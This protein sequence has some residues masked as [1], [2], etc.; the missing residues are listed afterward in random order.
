MNRLF[1]YL[2]ENSAAIITALIGVFGVLL[3]A[4]MTY[5]ATLRAQKKQTIDENLSNALSNFFKAYS[6]FCRTKSHEEFS[7]L[8]ASLD[9][10]RLF[11]PDDALPRIDELAFSLCASED[12]SDTTA[13]IYRQLVDLSRKKI[14]HY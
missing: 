11:C 2:L 13:A 8:L 12:I 6:A 5:L 14:Q 10:V 1:S 3:G 4:L 9:C 7:A